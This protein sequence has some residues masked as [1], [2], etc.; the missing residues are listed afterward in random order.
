M[1]NSSALADVTKEFL[2]TE[3]TYVGRLRTL[4]TDYADPLRL[5]SRSK[6]TS[7]LPAY[8]A[9]TLFGN[10]DNLL[11]VNEA[12]LED[13]EKMDQPNGP[14]IGD[15][16]LK[17]F[18][19][20]R[21][22]EHYKQYYAN[23]AE[24]QA[25]FEREMKKS[26]GFSAF[27]DVGRKL[28]CVPSCIYALS[29]R[30]KY[31]SADTKNRI[32]L[33]ELLMEPVQR[34]PRYTLMFRTMLKHM[35]PNDPQRAAL[36]EADEIASKIALAEEDEQT[37]RAAIMYCLS[38]SIEDFP[39]ALVSH[40]RRFIDCID[41]EDVP[42]DGPSTSSGGGS[43]AQSGGNLHCTLFLFDD[44]LVIVRRPSEKG[45]R[46]LAGL[47][48][49]DK[50]AKPGPFSLNKKKSGMSCKGMV[51]LTDVVATDVGGPS[52]SEVHISNVWLTLVFQISTC[53][54]R[55]LLKIRIIVG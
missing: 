22:F 48:N 42:I 49:P 45:G 23:R 50:M 8:A 52:T 17:H 27:V 7:I 20:L 13:L 19:K 2:S 18:K 35:A 43:A 15:I 25:I 46:M 53:T 24:A 44:K 6:D 10:I 16:A 11:P 47:D 26:Q 34:I 31:S 37:K 41:V 55:I 28:C 33:R 3:R 32:G 40:A 39:P 9:K 36:A 54:S 14:G 4:K 5:F 21:G 29:Q 1:T 38:A 30:I 51:D 12:F